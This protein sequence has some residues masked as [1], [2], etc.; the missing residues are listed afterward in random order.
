MRNNRPIFK[1]QSFKHLLVWTP[2]LFCNHAAQAVTPWWPPTEEV[3]PKLFR[4][5]DEAV[6]KMEV[7]TYPSNAVLKWSNAQ[8]AQPELDLKPNE[9]AIESL[10]RKTRQVIYAHLL[11]AEDI[12]QKAAKISDPTARAAQQRRVIQLAGAAAMYAGLRLEDSVLALQIREVYQLPYL[13]AASSD[14][15]DMI[16]KEQILGQVAASYNRTE[17][18]TPE[19]AAL[20]ALIEVATTRNSADA[21]RSKLAQAYAKKGDYA[22]AIAYLEAIRDPSIKGAKQLIP[23]YQALQAKTQGAT[24]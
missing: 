16:S 1:R 12:L 14:G 2:L 7:P 5:L 24:P 3:K 4:I 15:Q 21:A 18:I 8:F 6:G 10:K 19:I 9:V 22:R 11:V 17:Q 20:K 13:D 23:T